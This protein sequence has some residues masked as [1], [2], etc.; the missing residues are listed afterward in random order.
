M[1]RNFLTFSCAGSI[2]MGKSTVANHFRNLGCAVF[3]ADAC[4]HSL[5]SRHG[6]AVE[7]ISKLFPEAIVDGAVNRQ[8]LSR[9]VLFQQGVDHKETLRA[10]ERIVHP[11]VERERCLFRE[12]AALQN[13][14]LVVY[15]IPLLLEQR[16]NFGGIND[17][18]A[19]A[20]SDATA[21]PHNYIEEIVVVSA[22]ADKQRARVMARPNMDVTKLEQILDKQ[23][24]DSDKRALAD[25]VVD[26]NS[27]SLAPARSQVAAVIEQLMG[28]YP[29]RWHAFRK[30]QKRTPL[31]APSPSSS[32]SS[33]ASDALADESTAADT[34]VEKTLATHSAL[35]RNSFDFVLFDLDDTL[36]PSHAPILTANVELGKFLEEN[37]MPMTAKSLKDDSLRLLG[38]R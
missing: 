7:P 1:S 12:R 37:G 16:T 20:S 2:G 24:P 36:L 18:K 4:V 15:D 19:A 8:I 17:N 14:L 5:Y 32:S 22:A 38:A 33:H 9:L 23:M 13:T 34:D 27:D 31:S 35:L 30:L 21:M 3:D 29:D 25:Y 10:L 26:T 28:K 11:L 6:A